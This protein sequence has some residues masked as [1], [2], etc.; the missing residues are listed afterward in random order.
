MNM[1]TIFQIVDSLTPEQREQLQAYLEKQ[2]PSPTPKQPRI[3]G[4]HEHLGTGWMSEDFDAELPDEF[5][6]FDK[7]A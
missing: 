7:E 1:Q 5:W 4:L 2:E 6:G 3:L